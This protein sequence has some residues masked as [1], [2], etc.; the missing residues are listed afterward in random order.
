MEN[1]DLFKL[2]CMG[3]CPEPGIS[4]SMDTFHNLQEQP[5]LVKTFYMKNWKLTH[6][7]ILILEYLITEK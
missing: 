2:K 5:G 1:G 4:S 7:A 3:E 6:L